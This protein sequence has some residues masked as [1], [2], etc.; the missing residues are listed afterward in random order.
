M[1]IIKSSLF[2]ICAMQ[3]NVAI[4]SDPVT[5]AAAVCCG[6]YATASLLTYAQYKQNP[7]PYDKSFVFSEWNKKI[8][9]QDLKKSVSKETFLSFEQR[10]RKPFL[11]PQAALA[12]SYYVTRI[13]PVSDEYAACARPIACCLLTFC[14]CGC[15]ARKTAGLFLEYDDSE[16]PASQ[17]MEETASSS[18]K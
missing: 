7:L 6:S 2:L 1:N 9:R 17:N 13:I 14:S 16:A 8:I 12:K 15:D 10:W 11:D 4:S 3:V 18:S 5:L